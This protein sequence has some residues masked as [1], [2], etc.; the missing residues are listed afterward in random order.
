MLP[1]AAIKAALGTLLDSVVARID[2]TERARLEQIH[3]ALPAWLLGNVSV[4]RETW[5]V[6]DL[7]TSKRGFDAGASYDSAVA[8]PAL[9]RTF[10]D[11]VA[12]VTFVFEDPPA[13]M[14]WFFAS[15]W[16]EMSAKHERLSAMHGGS[17]AGS[18]QAEVDTWLKAIRAQADW[19]ATF[20]QI[21]DEEKTKRWGRNDW[22]PN[23]GAMAAQTQDAPRKA[24]LVHLKET[25][26]GDLSGASHLSGTG[27]I[28]QA[29]QMLGVEDEPIKE[30]YFSMQALAA[31]TLL[32]ALLS[33]VIVEG[34][35]HADLRKKVLGLWDLLRPVEDEASR[36]FDAHYKERLAMPV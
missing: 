15:A 10:A 13:R 9:A 28:M 6:I 8:F 16:K 14:R 18:L 3:V 30:R 33:E 29:A 27:M 19:W 22:W 36:L 5:K 32:L 7:L 12:A 11:G 31:L 20:A 4:A 24:R 34:T 17:A 2:G 21:T 26:Y 1:T 25:Y 35:R 23:P